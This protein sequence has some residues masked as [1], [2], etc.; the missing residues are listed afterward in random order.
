MDCQ[1]REELNRFPPLREA[2]EIDRLWMR[3]TIDLGWSE[4][5][6]EW[7]RGAPEWSQTTVALLDRCCL[8]ER[9]RARRVQD[10]ISL[11]QLY[12]AAAAEQS[13][14]IP[15]SDPTALFQRPPPIA[16][17]VTPAAGGR[18][19]E[20][21]WKWARTTYPWIGALPRDEHFVAQVRLLR[22]L[23]LRA[24]T[25]ISH[26][27]GG[28]PRCGGREGGAGPAGWSRSDVRESDGRFSSRPAG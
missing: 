19:Q 9:R 27:I 5:F 21:P 14:T 7:E 10:L 24:L 17:T 22:E 4:S 18:F 3:H 15:G 12:S 28:L 1:Q 11:V 23:P 2:I 20:I 8:W 16:S 6:A 13:L 25:R 26:S